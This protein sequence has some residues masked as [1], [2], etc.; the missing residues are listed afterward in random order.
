MNDSIRTPLATSRRRRIVAVALT[1][2]GGMVAV[3]AAL[4]SLPAGRA[5]AAP[6]A[7]LGDALWSTLRG[8]PTAADGRIVDGEE[9]SVFDDVP[10]V[11]KLDA[12]L[13]AAL[14]RAAT[15]AEADGVDFSVTS[16][17][18]SP[19]YQER[20]LR[21]AVATY[22]SR[23]EAAR[24]VATPTTS[25][26]VSGDAVDIGPYAA[27][28]WLVRYGA[29]YGLCQ[30]YGNEAWHYELRQ[31]AAVEGCPPMYADPTEDPRMRR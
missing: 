29:D 30:I 21:D 25:A 11:S 14:R 31:E 6:G 18:R 7:S 2:V 5:G 19:R 13:L 12:D 28:D 16:G 20:L 22:G 8:E 26:H 9:P 23:E 24:W 3:F 1:V 15:D 27:L 17:W 4:Q 10:A